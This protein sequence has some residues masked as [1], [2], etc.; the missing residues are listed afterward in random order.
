MACVATIGWTFG[1][2][3]PI[4]LWDNGVLGSGGGSSSS[5]SINGD[6]QSLISS[7]LVRDG[8]RDY[9]FL[10][11]DTSKKKKKQQRRK[12]AAAGDRLPLLLMAE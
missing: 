10:H 7:D 9:G 4:E 1:K 2:R 8:G 5:S 6:G 3:V 11:Y 12:H